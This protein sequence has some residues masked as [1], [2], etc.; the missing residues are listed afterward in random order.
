MH[1][2]GQSPPS[3][4]GFPSLR[5]YLQPQPQSLVGQLLQLDSQQRARRGSRGTRTSWTRVTHL[6]TGTRSILARPHSS[7]TQTRSQ[8]VTSFS[9]RANFSRVGLR[10]QSL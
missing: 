10:Q 7:T 6:V 2:N 8:R 9:T 4:E 3:R 1:A 5:N